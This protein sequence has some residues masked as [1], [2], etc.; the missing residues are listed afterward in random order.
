MLMSVWTD[1]P[2]RFVPGAKFYAGDQRQHLV[3]RKARWHRQ[4]MLI[5]FET[6]TDREIAG[7][8]R[9]QVLYVRVDDLPPLEEDEF[10]LH[11][12]IGLKVLRKDNGD[13]LGNITDVLETGAND[14]YVVRSSEGV[15]ILI[16]AVDSVISTID[17]ESGEVHIHVLPGLLP[18]P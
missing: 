16:P 15:D 1:F 10:Y 17:F 4:D 13:L 2:E 3:V 8:L 18:D 14:V 11:Q 5:A 9:N 12:L 6:Y 7:S